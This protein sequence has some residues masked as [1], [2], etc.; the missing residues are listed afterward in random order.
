[1]HEK[2]WSNF[3][4]LIRLSYHGCTTSWSCTCKKISL[5]VVIITMHESE[6]LTDT[7]CKNLND[8]S[9]TQR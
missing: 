3:N 9:N 8:F 1:M 7:G 4:R 2:E 5:S 6:P